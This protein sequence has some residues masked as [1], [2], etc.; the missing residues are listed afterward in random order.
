M[1]DG[2]IPR[3][4]HVLPY[5]TFWDEVTSLTPVLPAS[6][7]EFGGHKHTP[8]TPL[9]GSYP[10]ITLTCVNQGARVAFS[11]DEDAAGEG[12]GPLAAV[13]METHLYFTYLSN[14]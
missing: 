11:L 9:F 5:K 2:S 13:A 10:H 14:F 1:S 3:R 7:H 6:A 4:C 12:A 8:W